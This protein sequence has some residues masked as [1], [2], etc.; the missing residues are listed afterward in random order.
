MKLDFNEVYDIG[1]E[2]EATPQLNQHYRNEKLPEAFSYGIA[3]LE[4]TNASAFSGKFTSEILRLG[5]YLSNLLSPSD[6]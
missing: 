3:S 4:L 2:E 5:L 6:R 1:G